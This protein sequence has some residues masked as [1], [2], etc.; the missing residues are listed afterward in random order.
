MG[1]GI[2]VDTALE[3]PDLVRAL[4]VSGAS[5]P[6]FTDPWTLDVLTRWQAA[7]AAGDADAWLDAFE[8]F[9]MG[10][11][12]A[13]EDVDPEVMRQT[14]RMARHTIAKHS[15]DERDWQ[16][17][18]ANTWTRAASIPVPVLAINGDLD[19]PDHIA[20]AE[21][22][23]HLVTDG[24]AATVPGTAHCPNMEKPDVFNEI[25]AGFLRTLSHSGG[26]L[27]A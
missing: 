11:H 8:L 6:R 24:R 23:T 10:P 26:H 15:V 16:T 13:P 7:L 18:V 1:G 14:C 4:V 5:Q 3:H 20:M 22:L 12:R 27:A 21:Q 2:A 25:L 17:P 19:S 9:G